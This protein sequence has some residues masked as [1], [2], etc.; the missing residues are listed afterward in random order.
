M[1]LEPREEVLAEPG[2]LLASAWSARP[3]KG[4][5]RLLLDQIR[6]FPTLFKALTIRVDGG[7]NHPPPPPERVCG[8]QARTAPVVANR[9]YSAFHPR[10]SRRRANRRSPPRRAGAVRTRCRTGRSAW[11]K[12]DLST[13]PRATQATPLRSP[14]NASRPA[15]LASLAATVA[16]RFPIRP[17]PVFPRAAGVRCLAHHPGVSSGDDVARFINIAAWRPTCLQMVGGNATLL[18]IKQVEALWIT[19]NFL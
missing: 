15:V 4:A 18:S 11:H 8:C 5:P 1:P 2:D 10:G 9:A 19:V 7:K 12:R 3:I 13:V 17:E 16:W 14:R 6:S